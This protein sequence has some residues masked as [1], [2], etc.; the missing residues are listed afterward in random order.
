ML[1]LRIIGLDLS[2][3]PPVGLHIGLDFGTVR[4]EVVGGP[5]RGEGRW[6]LAVARVPLQHRPKR[7]SQ[8]GVVVPERERNQARVALEIAANVIALSLG[9]RRELSS[10]N[11]YVAF[12]AQSD[13]E[14]AWL[15]EASGLHGGLDGVALQSLAHRIPLESD[16]LEHLSDRWDG[17]A[18]VSEALSASRST[19]RFLDLMRLF[20]RA[21]KLSATRLGAPLVAFLDPRF[22]YSKDEVEHWTATLR[23]S[24]SHADQRRDFVLDSD[25]RPYLAR[26]EQAAWDVLM[27]KRNWRDSTLDRRDAWSSDGGIV[28]ASG[29]LVI[30]QHST[31]TLVAQLLDRWEEFPL[32]LEMRV[33]APATWWPSP[34]NTLATREQSLKVVPQEEWH[35]VKP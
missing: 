4:V 33:D 12:E 27:N 35:T 19:G 18:L 24:A 31:P 25:V 8:R 7:T 20:E 1:V 14:R 5:E 23:G 10:P 2:P 13:D 28:S 30:A 6:H 9:C 11:P 21:F 16:A 17:V 3:P 32:D 34:P 29:D 26:I 15:A 22:G